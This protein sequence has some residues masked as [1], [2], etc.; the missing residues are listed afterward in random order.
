MYRRI[1]RLFLLGIIVLSCSESD[2]E[3][4]TPTSTHVTAITLNPTSISL[5]KGETAT[6]TATVSPSDATNKRIIWSSSNSAVATVD[7]GKVSAISAGSADITATAD[8]N[9][10]QATCKITVTDSSGNGNGNEDPTIPENPVITGDYSLDGFSTVIISGICNLEPLMGASV[11]FGIVYSND[12]LTT[13]PKT[14]EAEGK[15]SN[16]KFSCEISVNP[17][18]EVYYYRAFATR[19][20][21]TFYGD[22]K[23]FKTKEVIPTSGEA[24][25]MGVSVKWASCNLGS[26]SPEGFGN[27]YAWGETQSK[28]S[29]I[30]DNYKYYVNGSYSKYNS[31]DGKKVLDL[32]DDA[33]NVNCG[34]N[35]RIPTI[36][37]VNELFE[38]CEFLKDIIY[39]G[40]SG[41]AFASK[42]T[43]NVIFFPD[44]AN[45]S[46]RT[47][48]WTSSREKEKTAYGFYFNYLGK[49][50][51]SFNRVNGLHIRPVLGGQVTSEKNIEISVSNITNSSCVV[52]FSPNA[53]GTYYWDI[54]S[55]ATFD[56]YGGTA[57]FDSYVSYHKER[58]ELNDYLDQG[59]SSY[60]F[61]DLS[62]KTQYV[63]FVAFCD[64]NGVATSKVFS[65]A[66]TTK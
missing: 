13:D 40:V 35:W 63:V 8:D 9:G 34:S 31:T 64:G 17:G 37:E 32:E 55:K 23:S 62:S 50:T 6:I 47:E 65:K 5:N 60:T 22:I 3:N 46:Y 7:G 10:K 38:E 12:D 24:I 33:A 39:Q 52:S 54:I 26:K 1:I 45:N 19:G 18:G 57:V 61:S 58:G 36:E 16:N 20:G 4:T 27:L 51:D 30:L 11:M 43:G 42:T 15:D 48:F 14:I 28:S 21:E 25:D 56:E 49:K 53:S 41:Q 59:E 29:Y 44:D 66:F 2:K